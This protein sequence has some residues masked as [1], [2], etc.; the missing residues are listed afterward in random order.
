[1]KKFAALLILSAIAFVSC[2]QSTKTDSE[3]NPFLTTYNT[4][5]DVP[6]FNKIRNEHFL[7]AINEGI[8]AHASEIE[9]IV[10]NPEPASFENTIAALDRSGFLLT[11]VNSVFYNLQS[12]HTN[13]E[14]QKIAQEASPLLSEHS[15]DILLNEGL[16]KRVKA[17]YDKRENLSLDKEQQMLLDKTYKRFARNGA[18]LDNEKKETLRGINSELSLLSLKFGDNLLAETNAFQMVIEEEND[19]AGLPQSVRDAAA[20]AAREAG[21]SDSWLITLHSPSR[22]PFLQYAQNRKLREK[23]MK[24]YTNRCNNDN[25]Y[26]NKEITSKMASLRVKRANLLGYK[27]HADFALEVTMAKNPATV[28]AFLDELW[29]PA[30]VNAKKEAIEL[31]KMIDA[32]GGNFKLESWDWPYYAEKLRQ[33]KFSFD[34]E[35]LRQ[36][37]ELQHVL[38]GMFEVANNLFGLQFVVLKDVPVYHP[39]AVVYQVLEADG[40]H[41]GI[42]YMDFH[43]RASKS[44][45]AWMTSFREQFIRNGENVPPVISM[46]MNFSKPTGEMPALLSFEEVET[47][48][49]EFG[50]ALHGL[51]SNVNYLTLSGT[52]VS[53]DFVEL[54]SQIM[55][56]WAEHPEVLKSFARH[57]KTGEPIPDELITKIQNA[58]KFNQGF[59]TTEYIAASYLDMDWHTLTD[60]ETQNPLQF[61]KNAM[62]RIGLIPQMDPRYRTTYFAHAFSWDYSAGYYSYLWAEVL[63]NDAFEAFLENGLFDPETAKSLRQYIFSPGGTEDPMELYIKFRG[64]A[65]SKEPMLKKRGLL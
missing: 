58:S 61:E 48:F 40:S 41:I 3:M 27:T 60:A 15:D 53:R 30:L 35:E 28:Y 19:L 59:A 18:L 57:Y 62:D 16:F 45:G 32:E 6:P 21:L 39:D 52:N 2:N 33:Q 17:V 12:A 51:L 14:L 44:G 23:L 37:F 47:L 7:P 34:E 36:Y 64:K 4:P 56:N 20:D 13:D 10:N 11:E 50:H 46:V 43:P 65:P 49:H 5:F 31:Q 38:Q 24:A 25:V 22:M 29:T 42:L 26:D 55:E 8:K 9:A 1:M 63:D 54:P